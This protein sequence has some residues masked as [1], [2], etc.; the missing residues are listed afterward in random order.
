LAEII[1]IASGK[2]GVGRSVLATNL[3]VYL[4]LS[5]KKVTLVDADLTGANLHTYLG[6]DFPKLSI[7]DFILRGVKDLNQLKVESRVPNLWLIPGAISDLTA[8]HLRYY[9]KSKLINSLYELDADYVIIDMGRGISFNTLDFFIA[10]DIKLLL[11]TPFPSSVE[12]CYRFIKAAFLR[13]IQRVIPDGKMKTF[14]NKFWQEGGFSSSFDFLEKAEALV[15]EF[16]S[17]IDEARSKFR[18]GLVLNQLKE[19]ED[20]KLG[21]MME[22]LSRNHLGIPLSYLGS[23]PYDEEMEKSAAA[24]KPLI[25]TNKNSASAYGVE[26]LANV[27]ISYNKE[28]GVKLKSAFE[29]NHYQLLGIPSNA[30]AEEVTT[31][32]ELMKELYSRN[33][34]A[35]YSLLSPKELF[36]MMRL[37][38]RAYQIISDPKERMHYDSR[39]IDIGELVES[40]RIDYRSLARKKESKEEKNKERYTLLEEGYSGEYLRKL[41]VIRNIT[42]EEISANTKISLRNL[43]LIEE[44]GFASLPPRVYLRGFLLEYAKAL[45]L[46]PEDAA[47]RYLTRYDKWR[48]GKG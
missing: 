15:P 34:L 8:T 46:N 24:G 5:Q 42:L 6:V 29:L 19:R 4:A 20:K 30:S 26:N 43:E 32:Y 12:G 35:A 28:G 9:K 37:V 16:V 17:R 13:H 47:I 33:S 25:I 44:E 7:A 14:L 2:G 3:G 23:I 48:E 10:S 31:G 1:G 27:I 38:R 11:V 18:I 45:G 22:R 36:R 40:N 39:L 41:R 21:L